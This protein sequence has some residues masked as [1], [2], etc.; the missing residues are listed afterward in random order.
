MVELYLWSTAVSA[1]LVGVL[2]LL[3]T[4]A[5]RVKG[6][7]FTIQWGYVS[8]LLLMAVVPFANLYVVKLCVDALLEIVKYA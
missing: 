8:I 4:V 2:V 3:S 7:G 6:D 1:I 5:L